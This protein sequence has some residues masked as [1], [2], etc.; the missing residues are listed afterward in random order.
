MPEDA[1]WGNARRRTKPIS[2]GATLV[3]NGL[4]AISEIVKKPS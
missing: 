2:D 3:D 4:K 1:A